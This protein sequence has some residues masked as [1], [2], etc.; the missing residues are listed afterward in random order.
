MLVHALSPIGL[1]NLS[2]DTFSRCHHPS[3]L[4][5]HPQLPHGL[6]LLILLHGLSWSFTHGF[7][8]LA[9]QEGSAVL[10]PVTAEPSFWFCCTDPFSGCQTSLGFLFQTSQ[11][12]SQPI[13]TGLWGMCYPVCGSGSTPP[14]PLS[15]FQHA[16][17]SQPFWTLLRGF[18]SPK[19]SSLLCRAARLDQPLPG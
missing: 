14:P 19:W 11:D 10:F 4:W 13:S 17:E 8:I 9:S 1:D 16:R 15:F 3:D 2:L 6:L 7:S 18:P 5:V 12:S